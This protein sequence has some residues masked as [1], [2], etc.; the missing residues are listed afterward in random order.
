MRVSDGYHP[1]VTALSVA[2]RASHASA[3]YPKLALGYMSSR[4]AVADELTSIQQRGAPGGNGLQRQ[5]L[6]GP[7]DAVKAC[8]G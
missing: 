3:A 8:E 7:V 1:A 5:L 2:G 6:Q 4:A